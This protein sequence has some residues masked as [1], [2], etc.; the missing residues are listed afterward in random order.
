MDYK[1][2]LI[3]LHALAI[4][5]KTAIYNEDAMTALELAGVTACKVNQCV[6]VINEI[7]TTIEELAT[8]VESIGTI[9]G[10]DVDK[11]ELLVL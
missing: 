5:A 11:E 6:D 7:I 1:E 3:K 9:V 4:T 8:D 2:Q 10:Y